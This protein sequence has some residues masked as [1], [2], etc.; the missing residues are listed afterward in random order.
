MIKINNIAIPKPT[1][2]QIGIMDLT[3]GDR[4]ANGLMILEKIATKRKID[5]SYNFLLGT[6]LSLLLNQI[7]STFFIVEYPDSQTGSLKTGTFYSGDRTAEIAD[8]YNNTPRWKNLK[9]NLIER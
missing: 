1:T 7:S 9:F 3:K 8:Y 2:C 6:E 5:L 4:N